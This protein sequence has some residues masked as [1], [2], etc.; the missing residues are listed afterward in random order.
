MSYDLAKI[1]CGSL[2]TTLD[3]TAHCFPE[4]MSHHYVCCTN[5]KKESKE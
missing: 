2:D 1:E 5:I 4:D 3:I